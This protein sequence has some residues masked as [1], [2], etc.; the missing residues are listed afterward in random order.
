M[1]QP[2]NLPLLDSTCSRIRV[3]LGVLAMWWLSVTPSTLI[4]DDVDGLAAARA[5][6]QQF[7]DVIDR[8]ED[9]VVSIVRGGTPNDD[10]RRAVPFRQRGPVDQS[11]DLS[12]APEAFGSGVIIASEAVGD[13]RYV[14]TNDHV[15]RASSEATSTDIRDPVYVR[16]SNHRSVRAIVIASDP[17]SDLA[18]LQLNLTGSGMDPSEVTPLPMGD[19][20]NARKGQMVLAMGNPYAI[21]RDGAASASWGIISNISRPAPKENEEELPGNGATATIHE[22]GTLL[23]VDTRLDLGMSGGALLNLN[24]ELIG[25][26]TSLAALKG[27][28][29]S[30]GYAIPIDDSMRRVIDSLL[31]GFEVEYGFLG[32]HTEDVDRGRFPLPGGQKSAARASFVSAGSPAARGGLRNQDVILS[33]NER[34]VFAASD[35]MREI[36]LLGPGANARLQVWRARE[37]RTA[38]ADVTLGKWPVMDDSLI[39]ATKQRY[40]EWRGIRVDYPTGRRRFLTSDVMDTYHRAVLILNVVDESPA[41]LAGLRPGDFIAAVDDV[42]VETPQEFY[43]AVA[44]L[45]GRVTLTRLDGTQLELRQSDN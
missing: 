26:T 33:I 20:T 11:L 14:L 30:V 22:Y 24:G 7:V 10:Q 6:E 5:V 31:H 37:R 15:L 2:S 4:A 35:L 42:K 21:A 18:V 43:E 28:E 16:L 40:P 25:L 17:R 34:P 38:R 41:Q 13:G 39:I 36:G 23:H 19:A 27:Y 1:S 44:N 32:I 29:K 12:S 45:S 3:T 9:A 8:C